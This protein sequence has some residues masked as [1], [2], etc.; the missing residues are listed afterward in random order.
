MSGTAPSSRPPILLTSPSALARS[1]YVRFLSL[2]TPSFVR[3]MLYGQVLSVAL[4]SVSVLTTELV[5]RN[6]VLP[7]TQVFF[8]YASMFIVYTPY[9]VY[10]CM[11]VYHLSR[12]RIPADES[13][14][15]D[16]MKGWCKLIVHD[17]WKY[18]ILTLGDFEAGYLYIKAFGYTDLMS[19]MLLDAWTIPVCVLACWA[20]M[21]VRYHWTQVLGVVICIG[22]LALL[23]TSDLLTGKNGDA[24][25]SGEGDGFM[26]AA[27]TLYGFVN[28][29]EEFLSTA[30]TVV[31]GQ[32]GLWG[33][34]ASSVQ[35]SILERQ[36]WK[37]STWDGVTAGLLI[38]QTITTFTTYSIQMM[39][40]RM[41]S[42]PFFNISLLTSD[43]YGLLFGLF[44]FH[45]SPYW[46]YFVAFAIVIFGLVIYFWHATPEEQGM[47]KIELPKYLNTESETSVEDD[48][49]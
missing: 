34:V 37:T 2:W 39:L 32:M 46:L 12:V 20:V 4:T 48:E 31:L 7:S 26:L 29:V 35:S 1:V 49:G 47:T 41:A 10:K 44:L 38:G 27:S 16:G 24:T 5:D 8:S 3:S 25:R 40:F 11:P 6:W 17:G 22:G 43:F 45:Y 18:L 14:C 33:M 23:V 36:K 15:Q 13:Y 19:C 42:S 21:H 9:T 28:A 30:L